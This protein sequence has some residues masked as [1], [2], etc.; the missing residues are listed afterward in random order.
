M[1]LIR[2]IFIISTLL[3]YSCSEED[4][5][6]IFSDFK[7]LFS[8][9]PDD[10]NEEATNIKAG[11][12]ITFLDLSQG[13]EEHIWSI[14]SGC[15]FIDSNQLI[16]SEKDVKIEFTEPGMK[17][18][19]VYNKFKNEFQF[20]DDKLTL[21]YGCVITDK[22]GN[23]INKGDITKEVLFSIHFNVLP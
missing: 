22:D 18:I 13:V 4:F 3:L 11:S 9:N 1:K 2:F 8:V 23:I 15:K 12:V 14:P 16:S 21:L 6:P 19:T 20:R 10:F 7:V 5:E 17:T